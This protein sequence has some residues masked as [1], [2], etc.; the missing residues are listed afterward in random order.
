MKCNTFMV[1]KLPTL[2]WQPTGIRLTKRLK[3]GTDPRW[4]YSL[5]NN[6]TKSKTLCKDIKKGYLH[7]VERKLATN[8]TASKNLTYH[9]GIH[10]WTRTTTHLL[11]H[12]WSCSFRTQ[13]NIVA[14]GA[15]IGPKCEVSSPQF[16]DNKL[17][18]YHEWLT[19]SAFIAVNILHKLCMFNCS[20]NYEFFLCQFGGFVKINHL[21]Y[22]FICVFS[23]FLRVK[24]YSLFYSHGFIT[25]I[26]SGISS[27]SVIEH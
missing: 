15:Q 26:K 6:M 19:I 11:G 12:I 14:C 8:H 17:W 20:T 25:A 24:W 5:L 13:P 2:V 16:C 22:Q 27:N 7:S 9:E 10:S 3:I 21:S 4:S 1:V 23:L 18:S